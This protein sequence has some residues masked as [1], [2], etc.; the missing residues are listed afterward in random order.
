MS[1]PTGARFEQ[2]LVVGR[3]AAVWLSALALHKALG[4]TGVKVRVVE[5]PSLLTPADVYSAVPSLG[6]LHSLLGLEEAAVLE[7]T[8]GLPVLGQR[9]ANWSKSKPPFIH[10]YDTHR[11]AL[12]D[13]DFLQFWVKARGEGMK[14]E[15][16]DF[17]LAAAAARQ[18]RSALSRDGDRPELP[19]SPGY[20]LD[21]RAYVDLLRRTAL[22]AGIEGRGADVRSVQRDGDRITSVTLMDGMTVQGDLFIDA[23][24]PAAVLASGAPDAPFE[25]WRQWFNADRILVAEAPRLKPLPAFSQI[26]AFPAGWVGLYPLKDRTALVAVYDSRTMSDQAVL[27]ALPALTGLPLTGEAAVEGFH[28]G[29]RPAW[30]GNCIAIGPAAVSLEPLDAIQLHLIH[31]GLSN[32]IALFPAEVE[33]MPEAEAYNRAM[34]SH[35]A[36]IRDFLITHYALNQRFDDPVWDRARNMALPEKLQARLRVFAA[37]GRVPLY[38]DESFQQ[39]NWAQI[40]IGH[41]LIPASYDPMVDTVQVDEQMGKVRGLLSRIAEEVQ[42]MPVLDAEFGTA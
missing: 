33:S 23:S 1:P 11:V 18:G 20:H 26:A 16:D 10:G 19:V 14:V 35:L 42:A 17:S 15:L 38:D 41:G 40:L 27:D 4:R 30:T 12:N 6:A 9:F 31:T 3:D 37:R 34:A 13:I 8:R 5:M 7:A 28:P 29:A 2:V 25:S 21:A 39:Q 22:Q 32:L 24:G 36:N